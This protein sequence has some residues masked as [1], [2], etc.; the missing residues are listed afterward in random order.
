MKND[1]KPVLT[2]EEILAAFQGTNFGHTQYLELLRASVLKTMLQYRCGHTI[3][4]IMKELGLVTKNEKV[5][6][7]GIK[8]MR[9]YFAPY[10]HLLKLGG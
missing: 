3:T 9:E 5:S 6:V 1:N 4:V 7:K 10:E 2:E 8:F